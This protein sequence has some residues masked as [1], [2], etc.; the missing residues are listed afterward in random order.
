MTKDELAEKLHTLSLKAMT[1][2][3]RDMVVPIMGLAC[4]L[5]DIIKL[6]TINS[7]GSNNRD[8][9]TGTQDVGP[10]AR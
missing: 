4:E 10:S 6:P 3:P 7:S 9:Y 8:R 1:T 2:E 5:T